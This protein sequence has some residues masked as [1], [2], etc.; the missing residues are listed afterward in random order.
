MVQ[1]QPSKRW[2]Y[3]TYRVIHEI[4]EILGSYMMGIMVA[5]VAYQVFGRYVLKQTPAW[6]EETVLL[7]LTTFGFLSIATGFIHGS[8]LS[9]D[10]LDAHLPPRIRFVLDRLNQLLVIG[11]G[12]FLLV[13]GYRFTVL[14]WSSRLPVTGLPN[15]LQYLIVPVTGLVII[16][17]GLFML[18][19][20]EK[21]ERP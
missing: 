18:I 20:I 13:Y 15:G 21:E 4:V 1:D 7:C 9:V 14:T 2:F 8:H 12:F 19:G 11:F 6:T 10:I 3:K 17:G 16:V 5:L